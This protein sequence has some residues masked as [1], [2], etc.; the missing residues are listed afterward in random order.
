MTLEEIILEIQSILLT[1]KYYD[2]FGPSNKFDQG[3]FQWKSISF[4]LM[5]LFRGD[6]YFEKY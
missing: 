6:L 3:Y 4:I 2:A 5:V 1:I